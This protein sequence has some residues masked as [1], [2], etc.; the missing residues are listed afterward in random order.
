MSGAA[1]A[2]IGIDWDSPGRV[3]A[4]LMADGLAGGWLLERIERGARHA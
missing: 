2:V 4:E 1:W 3:S